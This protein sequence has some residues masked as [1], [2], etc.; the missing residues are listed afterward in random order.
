MCHENQFSRHSSFRKTSGRRKAGACAI[1]RDGGCHLNLMAVVG[2]EGKMAVEPVAVALADSV[3]KVAVEMGAIAPH[4]HQSPARV[5]KY[6][7]GPDWK[8]L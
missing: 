6:V 7:T 1:N 8:F 4:T 3:Q 2:V 5:P